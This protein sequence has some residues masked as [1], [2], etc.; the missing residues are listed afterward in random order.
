[1]SGFWI[2]GIVLNV[3]LTGL[4]I[5]WVLREMK[6]RDAAPPQAAGKTPRTTN[7]TH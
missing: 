1:M 3:S 4:A 5:W 7:D 6:P 2:L